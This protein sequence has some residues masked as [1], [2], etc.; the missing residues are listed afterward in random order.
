MTQSIAA[1]TVF[2]IWGIGIFVLVSG[3]DIRVSD[4][5]AHLQEPW[6]VAPNAYLVSGISYLAGEVEG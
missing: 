3:F 5:K 4:L 6:S 2:G 1:K